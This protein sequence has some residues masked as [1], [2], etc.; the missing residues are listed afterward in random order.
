MHISNQL[1]T[2]PRDTRAVKPRDSV[3]LP[4]TETRRGPKPAV[5]Q[6]GD[7]TETAARHDRLDLAV[8]LDDL[9]RRTVGN[10]GEKAVA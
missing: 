3:R 8:V 7:S 4:W 9:Q 2:L 6:T 1:V 5:A 10:A